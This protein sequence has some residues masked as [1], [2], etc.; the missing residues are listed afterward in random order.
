MS[1]TV[2]Y[3]KIELLLKPS[4]GNF[5]VPSLD[6][7]EFEYCGYL[8]TANHFIILDNG[9]DAVNG[10]LFPLELVQSYKIHKGA[11]IL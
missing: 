4:V 8:I 11:Q 5:R 1:E 10:T 9:Q 3:P 6:K 2:I 7:R